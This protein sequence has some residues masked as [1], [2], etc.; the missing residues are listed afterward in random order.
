MGEEKKK[1]KKK[2]RRRK[3]MF[4]IEGLTFSS[5]SYNEL[6]AIPPGALA[7]KELKRGVFAGNKLTSISPKIRFWTQMTILELDGT[8]TSTTLQL[9]ISLFSVRT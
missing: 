9:N 3:P 5:G 6:R 2:K 1:K 8:T 7:I 4:S